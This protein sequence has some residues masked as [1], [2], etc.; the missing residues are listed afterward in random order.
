ML[1]P[2]PLRNG[3]P[4]LIV[5]DST[6]RIRFVYDGYD[7]SS[8]LNRIS[9]ARLLSCSISWLIVQRIAYQLLPDLA[10]TLAKSSIRHNLGGQQ[11]IPRTELLQ[12]DHKSC[13]DE[14]P[15]HNALGYPA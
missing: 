8:T 6:G 1:A 2:G 3:D 10:L 14:N 13:W 4:T 9:N 5:L 11:T 7:G 15:A 12:G